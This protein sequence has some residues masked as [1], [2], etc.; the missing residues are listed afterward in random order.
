MSDIGG[1]ATERVS[2]DALGAAYVAAYDTHLADARLPGSITEPEL[3]RHRTTIAQQIHNGP[4]GKRDAGAITH[5]AL[6]RPELLALFDADRKAAAGVR[7]AQEEGGDERLNALL[8][9]NRD[10]SPTNDSHQ[11][12]GDL[13]AA[14]AAA[15]S[16]YLSEATAGGNPQDIHLLEQY[17]D[18]LAARIIGRPQL[19]VETARRDPTMAAGLISRAADHLPGR[20]PDP[21]PKGTASRYAEAAFSFAEAVNDGAGEIELNILRDRRRELALEFEHNVPALFELGKDEAQTGSRY[22]GLLGYD[23]ARGTLQSEITVSEQAFRDSFLSQGPDPAKDDVAHYLWLQDQRKHFELGAPGAENLIYVDR[24][25]AEAAERLI[26]D[27]VRLGGVLAQRPDLREAL[28]ADIAGVKP[29]PRPAQ[30]PPAPEA[31]PPPERDQNPKSATDKDD[32]DKDKP[33][34]DKKPDPAKKAANAKADRPKD[35][36]G[37]EIFETNGSV[38]GIV[39]D[40]TPT[41]AQRLEEQVR[42]PNAKYLGLPLTRSDGKR[43]SLAVDGNLTRALMKLPPERLREIYDN[44]MSLLVRLRKADRL[45][46]LEQIAHDRLEIGRRAMAQAMFRRK[47][48]RATALHNDMH[49]LLSAEGRELPANLQLD[50]AKHRH[51]ALELA[52]KTVALPVAKGADAAKASVK[53]ARNGWKVAGRISNFLHSGR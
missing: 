34:T 13:P 27:P 16:R 31:P 40:H 14:Y 8:T 19:I 1:T 52:G 17:Q 48:E 9:T 5:I 25:A 23:L 46:P 22:A 47:M 44:N 35:G 49:P 30:H 53:S 45:S 7:F 21:D 28:E 39:F 32:P 36:Q 26:A 29:T 37:R 20:E 6:Y 42:N 11:V 51:W 33:P 12:F 50:L 2:G 15:R 4:G 38:T 3:F 18:I 43:S 41:S 24:L 10:G